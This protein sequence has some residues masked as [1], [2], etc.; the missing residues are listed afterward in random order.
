MSQGW[1]TEEGR[2]RRSQGHPHGTDALLDFLL[3]QLDV[4]VRLSREV[5][6]APGMT[7]DR[8]SGGSDLLEDLRVVSRVL[9]DG[10][11]RRLRAMIRQRLEHGGRI[12]R[13]GTVIKGQHD[14]AV[15]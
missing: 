6:V 10:E 5:L 14:L 1:E 8:V 9:A 7:P 15:T 13:P 4:V 12:A 3:G 2:A 11:E